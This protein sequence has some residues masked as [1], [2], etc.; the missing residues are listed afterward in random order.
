MPSQAPPTLTGDLEPESDVMEDNGVVRER[1][2]DA[3]VEGEAIEDAPI[4]GATLPL[5][6]TSLLGWVALGA[7]V[8]ATLGMVLNA[9]VVAAVMRPQLGD[10]QAG[11][12]GVAMLLVLLTGVVVS[13][14]FA[15]WAI[16][17]GCIAVARRRGV[18]PGIGAVILGLVGPWVG[19]IAAV[20]IVVAALSGG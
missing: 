11:A 12:V 17:Q 6:S 1:I 15:L 4:E 3:P 5:H 16:V 2:E 14:M 19:G 10:D 13:L 8:L 20:G 9:V 7:G 18:G